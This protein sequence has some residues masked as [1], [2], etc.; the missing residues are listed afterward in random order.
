MKFALQTTSSD[1]TIARIEQLRQRS[2]PQPPAARIT[3]IIDATS[4]RRGSWKEATAAQQRLVAEAASFGHLGIQLIHFGGGSIDVFPDGWSTS[5]Q[6]IT[7]YMQGIRCV[8]GNTQIVASLMR[9]VATSPAPT[10]IVVIGDAFEEREADLQKAVMKVRAKSIPI[11]AFFDKSNDLIN[12]LS[13]QFNRTNFDSPD[14]E[15]FRSMAADTGGMFGLFGQTK[16]DLSS[17]MVATA[18]YAT[19]GQKA[20]LSLASGNGA[21]AEAAARILKQ[22]PPPPK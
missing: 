2:N 10:I 17:L 4:S 8:A 13:R 14:E 5:P 22:L 15:V 21:K 3:F 9:A 19:G 16:L 18:A 12:I 1:S 6:E 7:S 11:F 20:L